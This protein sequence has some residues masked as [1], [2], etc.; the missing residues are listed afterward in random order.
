MNYNKGEE[1]EGK[2][3]V[4]IRV[5]TQDSFFLKNQSKDNE[6]VVGTHFRGILLRKRGELKE[7]RDLLL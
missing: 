6:I 1:T 5:H 3:L 2:V 7:E 4:E